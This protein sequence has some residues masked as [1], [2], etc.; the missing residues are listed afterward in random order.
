VKIDK[1]TSTSSI[2]SAD[3]KLIVSP[4]PAN[5]FITL[6][7]KKPYTDF[8]IYDFTGKKVLNGIASG[9]KTSINVSSL[10]KGSYFIITSNSNEPARFCLK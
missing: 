10:S 6:E 8:E 9:N 2:K 5:D 3:D 4:N 7:S 1:S